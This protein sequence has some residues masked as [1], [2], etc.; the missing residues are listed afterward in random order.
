MLLTAAFWPITFSNALW[1][2]STAQI[3]APVFFWGL[4]QLV[5]FRGANL[6]SGIVPLKKLNAGKDATRMHVAI[7]S[8]GWFLPEMGPRPDARLTPALDL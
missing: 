4:R 5:I 8:S 6:G 1:H 3:C 7:F 2:D